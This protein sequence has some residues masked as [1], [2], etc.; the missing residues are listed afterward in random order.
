MPHRFIQLFLTPTPGARLRAR[1]A[2]L[3][4]TLEARGTEV[5]LTDSGYAPLAIDPRADHVCAVGGDGTLRY[6]VDAARK[7]DRPVAVSVYPGGT[8]NLVAMEY[9]CP[10]KPEA[11]ARRLLEGLPNVRHFASIA[12]L[13]LLACASAGPD[14]HA[15]AGVS[16]AMKAR[17]GRYAYVAAFLRVLARWPRPKLVLHHDGAVTECEA[18]Y[19]AKGPYFAGPWS[20]APDATGADPSL[21]VVALPVA[22][23]RAFLRFVWAMFRNRVPDL[24]DAHSFTCRELVISGPPTVP[25]QGDGDVVAYLPVTIGMEADPIRFV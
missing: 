10:A 19:I 22:T 2:A 16:S 4:R 21:H 1:A 3:C 14:S 7:L 11:F 18:V 8:V 15:V 20:F 9:R 12:G 17:L 24:A 6:V 23:R 25:L 5:L 13:P